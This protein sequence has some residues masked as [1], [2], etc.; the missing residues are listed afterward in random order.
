MLTSPNIIFNANYAQFTFP[1]LTQLQVC[2][3]TMDW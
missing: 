2:F 1:K 3:Q